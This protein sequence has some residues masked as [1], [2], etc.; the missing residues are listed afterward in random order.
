MQK[1]EPIGL[2][3]MKDKDYKIPKVLAVVLYTGN[4]KWNPKELKDIEEKLENFIEPQGVYKLIDVNNFNRE[5]LIEDE[6]I[7]SKAMLIESSK[8]QEELYKNINDIIENQSKNKENNE[9]NWKQLEK[10]LRYELTGSEDE[11]TINEFIE[12]IRTAKGGEETMMRA[13]RIINKEKR[14]IKA[15]GIT[16]GIAMMARK[17][18]N[19]MSIE[20]IKELT[21][22]SEE[23]IQSL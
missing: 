3:T 8:G 1:Y 19:K 16:E 2:K 12:T 4:K 10:I 23:K 5:E 17:L 6:L 14:K 18:K 20:E 21:G 11:K 22:L 9:E 13:A 7:T 15:E